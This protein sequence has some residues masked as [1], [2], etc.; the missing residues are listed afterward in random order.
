[1]EGKKRQAQKDQDQLK[2]DDE[3][4]DIAAAKAQ[5]KEARTKMKSAEQLKGA[6]FGVDDRFSTAFPTSPWRPSGKGQQQTFRSHG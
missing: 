1:M 4:Q 2:K 3:K 5:A 6:I